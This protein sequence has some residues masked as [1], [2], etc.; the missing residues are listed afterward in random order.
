M[1]VERL[2]GYYVEDLA[3]ATSHGV[4]ITDVTQHEYESAKKWDFWGSLFY[5]GTVYTTI[6]WYYIVQYRLYHHRLVLH[7]RYSTS[8][9]QYNVQDYGLFTAHS[10]KDVDQFHW[11]RTGSKGIKIA[12][13]PTAFM[14]ENL[15]LL[16]AIE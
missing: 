9:V 12:N 8:R 3:E 2:L 15:V 5:A 6:G 14:F 10:A 11:F 4:D 7:G 16:Y 1:M 13:T